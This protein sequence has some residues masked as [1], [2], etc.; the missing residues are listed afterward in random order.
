MP[1][2]EIVVNPRSKF[3]VFKTSSTMQR[4]SLLAA[5]ILSCSSSSA[6]A[7]GLDQ[8]S[9]Q[10]SLGQPLQSSVKLI[11]ADAANAESGCFK[12]ALN[13]LDGSMVSPVRVKVIT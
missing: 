1:I 2:K 4:W 7:W 3:S 10:S 5:V 11:G 9:V 6:F 8:V 13:G 12:A